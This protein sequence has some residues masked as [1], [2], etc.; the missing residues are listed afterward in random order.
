[1]TG[2]ATKLYRRI[3]SRDP[4]LVQPE[5]VKRTENE[6]A[7]RKARDWLRLRSEDDVPE[8]DDPERTDD[9]DLSIRNVRISER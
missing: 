3:R 4:N 6:T 8:W 5:R 9:D 1:M 2:K 7:R